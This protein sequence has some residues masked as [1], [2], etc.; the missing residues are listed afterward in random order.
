MVGCRSS[1]TLW[2]ILSQ[3]RFLLQFV[4]CAF[5]CRLQPDMRS[6]MC[7]ACCLQ[8]LAAH[9]GL[10]PAAFSMLCTA[11]S[12]FCAACCLLTL[13]CSL[14]PSACCRLRVVPQGCFLPDAQIEV[15]HPRVG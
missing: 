14:L 6:P 12:L 2:R 8:H 3:G 13:A 1:V 7:A 9:C 5:A 10:L 15:V 11:C 4:A